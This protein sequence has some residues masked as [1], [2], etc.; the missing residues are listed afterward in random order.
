MQRHGA[1]RSRPSDL[2]ARRDR[3]ALKRRSTTLGGGFG[4]VKTRWQE[5][6]LYAAVEDARA[7]RRPRRS[8]RRRL[9]HRA[10]GRRGLY[11]GNEY[12]QGTPDAEGAIALDGAAAR[13]LRTAKRG[14]DQAELGTGTRRV[15]EFALR[16]R[17]AS[18]GRQQV[19]AVAQGEHHEVHRRRSGCASRA[20]RGREAGRGRDRI[21]DNMCMSSCSAGGV[22]RRSCCRTSTA[23]SSPTSARA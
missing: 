2:D 18:N 7:T 21:V 22:R 12:E 4:A 9:D 17:R 5:P 15:F 13:R 11:A 8:P 19:T 20:R 14:L 3:L 1:V 6:D 10:R 16:L 23:T